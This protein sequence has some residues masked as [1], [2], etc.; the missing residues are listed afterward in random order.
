MNRLGDDLK[1]QFF[2]VNV[3]GDNIDCYYDGT[4]YGAINVGQVIKLVDNNWAKALKLAYQINTTF[5]TQFGEWHDFMQINGCTW[6]RIKVVG[7]QP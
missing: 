2:T 5:R 4:K 3:L 1:V 7:R 6:E